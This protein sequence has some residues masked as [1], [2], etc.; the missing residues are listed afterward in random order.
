VEHDGTM[1]EADREKIRLL[2]SDSYT[3]SG[4]VGL[5]NVHQRLKLIYGTESSLWVTQTDHGTIMAQITFP[6]EPERE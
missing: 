3:D 6:L 1:T 4:R 2:L 5:R